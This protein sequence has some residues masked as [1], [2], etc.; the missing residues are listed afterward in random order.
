MFEGFCPKNGYIKSIRKYISEFGKE[1][2]EKE[3]IEGPP[4]DI[5]D[6]NEKSMKK[7]LVEKEESEEFNQRQL[8]KY[9]L[10]RLKYYYAVAEFDSP[11]TAKVVYQACDGT[12]YESS[13]NVFDLRYI[14]NDM[15]FDDEPMEETVQLPTHYKPCSF[16][17]NALQHTKV[18][19]TWDLDDNRRSE[20]TKKK[21]TKEDLK[22]MDFSNLIG[23][24]ES[25]EDDADKY[26]H[27]LKGQETEMG[28]MEVTFSDV[29]P[30][31]NV[32]KKNKKEKTKR[33]EASAQNDELELLMLEDDPNLAHSRHFDARVIMNEKKRKK[34][35]DMTQQE[36]FEV[37]LQDNRFNAVLES[38]HFAID[39]T[40]PRYDF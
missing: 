38:H 10:D 31:K 27:L 39:P 35:S 40:H 13:A 5:F 6:I 20:I 26:R 16:V 25:D 37:D 23:S 2:L 33:K 14:P 21:I 22:N 30:E 19:L 28:N 32:N 4:R 17:T 9:Q 3:N 1:R 36:D 29:E 34:S 11:S 7:S 18:N 12:E 24:D 8:R 15:T